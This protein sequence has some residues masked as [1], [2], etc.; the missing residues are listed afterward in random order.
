MI[1]YSLFALIALFFTLSSYTQS[2]D[3]EKLKGYYV[4]AIGPA[5]MSGRVTSI[6]VHP[7]HKDHILVGTASGGVWQSV[8][9]G[10]TWQP[11][12][13]KAPV[14][15]IGAVAFDPSNPTVL[16]AG[17]G[18]GNPRNSQS[19]GAGIFKSL[20]GGKN[21]TRMGLEN[22]KTIHRIIPDPQNSQT[23]YV[24]ATGSAWGPNPERGVFKTTDGGKT[25]NKILF[26]DD[27][28]GCADLIMDPTNPNKLFAAMWHYHRQP[29]FFESGGESSGLY[30]TYDGGTTWKKLGKKEGLPDGPLGR[31]GLAIAANKPSVVYALIESK[32]TALYRSTD[33]GENWTMRAD[34]NIGNRPFYYADI[35][36]DP[37]NENRVFNLFSTVSVS[38]DGGKTFNSLI[39][40]YKAHP[41]HHAFWID[42][43]NSDYIIE[44][45]DGGLNIS[46]DG[47]ANWRFI[48]NLPLAQFYHINVDNDHPYNIYGGMQ[49]NGS[50]VGPGYVYEHGGMRN[51]HWQEVMFGDGFDVVPYPKNSRYGYA[52]YQGGH[53]SRYDRETGRKSFIQPMHPD[54][55]PLR[56]NWNAAL[57]QDPFHD[58][59]IYFGSQFVHYSSNCGDSWEV[60]SP[61]LTTND[62][63]RQKQALSGGLTI[64][65]TRAE[66]YTTLLAIAPSPLDSQVIWVGTDDGNLQL[67]QDRGKNW[68]N[69]A[70]KLPGCPAGSWIPQIRASSYHA[71]EAF[72]VV[73]DYRRNNWD[74][75]L[76]HT[77]DYGK[78]WKRLASPENIKGHVWSVIQD[79]VE[80]N[81]LFLGT[82]YGLYYSLDKGQNWNHWRHNDFPAVA[83]SDLAI[84]PR[85]HDLIIGTFGRSAFVLDD[86]RPLRRL[87]KDQ[88]KTFED[89]LVVFDPPVAYRAP[90]KPARGV[91]F[92][93]QGDFVGQNRSSGAMISL[94]INPSLFEPAKK[95]EKG[96]DKTKATPGKKGKKVKMWVMNEAG[97]TIRT[98]SFKADSLFSR[99]YWNMRE[100]GTRG[101]VRKRQKKKNDDL[102][103]G[104]G[105]LPGDYKIVLSYG[106]FKDSCELTVL[107]H[108]KLG[109]N[110]EEAKARYRLHKDV[111]AEL[112]YIIG[113]VEELKQM[114]STVDEMN[115]VAAYLPDSTAKD[116]RKQG[117]AV[118]DSVNQILDEIFL[119][120]GFTGYDHVTI[121]LSAKAGQVY[122][123]LYSE[124]VTQ[125]NSFRLAWNDMSE[126][127]QGINK[128]IIALESGAWHEYRTE[129]E[130][131]SFD[132]FKKYDQE[133]EDD[134]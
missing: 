120:E 54:K 1:R 80:E 104:V 48:T 109:Y 59:G 58:C 4:R 45:N 60:L 35:Y 123:Y 125:N 116:F 40:Y 112:K 51:H 72:V 52:M 14:Q 62:T 67:T 19:S 9:G 132:F 121:N 77:I 5:G 114:L 47:G 24:A 33:G 76:Y 57:A 2:I 108:P 73:N 26:I 113:R 103:A 119:K 27:T 21:W 12:F 36:V 16:W 81:L 129:A 44:G 31:M 20:D 84:Q 39:S 15:S 46:R 94:W 29:W 107:E 100:D 102:P 18:E 23:L 93:G 130:K 70:S 106:K 118:K 13:D 17:S 99:V 6:D 10:I 7:E 66:N 37:N 8:S 22:T 43:D 101:L 98:T 3:D 49:D 105:V 64:D 61:D 65:A 30:V 83:V 110:Q 90:H 111:E 89:T 131:L 88:G 97:D 79:P 133:K 42:P 38:Q 91:R 56:Y 32:K 126:T 86:I 34:K 82:E 11:L 115:R 50:W 124:N 55:T 117:K 28:T 95:A 74:P 85:E 122:S 63:A 92:V 75:Y 134:R 87:V 127:F 128:R 41:D 69:L 68:T 78:S 96:K 53:I 71:G 25:W